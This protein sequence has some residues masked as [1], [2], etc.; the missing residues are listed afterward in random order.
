MYGLSTGFLYMC[1]VAGTVLCCISFDPGGSVPVG[2]GFAI[3]GFGGL[4]SGLTLKHSNVLL[5]CAGSKL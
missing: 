5:A 2:V 4:K 3:V 1:L